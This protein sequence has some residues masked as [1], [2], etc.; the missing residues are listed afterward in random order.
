MFLTLQ[1]PFV[2][3]RYLQNKPSKLEKPNWPDPDPDIEKIL[4]FGRI[5]NRNI[6]YKG[7]WDGEKLYCN[8]KSVFNFCGNE[9]YNFYK[10]LKEPFSSRILFRR[11]QSDGKFM[12]KFEIGFYDNFEENISSY[13]NDLK[14]LLYNHINKY[15]LCNLKIKIG[16]RLSEYLPLIHSGRYLADAYFWASYKGDGKRFFN[17]TISEQYISKCEPIIIIQL[18]ASS[19]DTTCLNSNKIETSNL[20]LQNY[21]VNLYFDYIAHDYNGNKNHIKSW[22]IAVPETYETLPVENNQF[23]YYDNVIRYLRINL[24]RLHVEKVVLKKIIEKIGRQDIGFELSD[25]NTEKKVLFHLHKILWNLSKHSRNKQNQEKLVQ[26]AFTVEKLSEEDNIEY[27]IEG[28]QYVIE[29]LEKS[30]QKNEP[31]INISNKI[32]NYM[33]YQKMGDTI[34]IGSITGNFI[35]KSHLENSLNST[36][37]DM[38]PEVK[39]ELLKIA[40]KIE[41]SQNQAAA[42]LFNSFSEELTKPKPEQNKGKLKQFWDSLVKTMPDVLT[43]G[44]AVAGIVALF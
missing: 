43:I 14:S 17:K 2:D 16:S 21:E 10:S 28:L 9:N 22:F 24:L 26:M 37:A 42:L 35:N 3:Y 18:N 29:W 20:N 38:N 7:P 4:Y 12:A 25:P 13:H 44:K 33:E 41:D 23:E 11:F 39:Q 31:V 1:F 27:Q 36:V 5:F 6:P 30:S 19:F 8:V 32:I 40:K 34:T 15:L